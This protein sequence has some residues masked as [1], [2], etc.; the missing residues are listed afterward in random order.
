MTRLKRITNKI[1]GETASTVGTEEFGAEIGQFGSAKLGT[2]NATGDVATIQSLPAWDNG[3]IDAVIPNQQYPTLPEMTGVFKVITHQTG[4]LHQEG[5]S[6]WD[7]ATEYYKESYVKYIPETITYTA[8]ASIGTSTGITGASVDVD[9]FTSQITAQGNYTFT[10]DGSNWLYNEMTTNLTLYG[11]A[12]TGTPVEDDEIIISLVK[13]VT[14]NE[15]KIYISNTDNN[16]NNNPSTDAINWREFVT[17]GGGAGSIETFCITSGN[18]NSDGQ[19]DLLVVDSSVNLQFKVGN[20]FNALNGVYADG[21]RFVSESIDTVDCSTL[22][23]GDYNIFVDDTTTV[24]LFSNA[25]YRQVKEPTSPSANDVWLDTSVKPYVSKKYNG[26]TWDIY[27][28]IPLPQ[29]ITIAS[30]VIS[31]INKVGYY[32]DGMPWNNTGETTEALP[33]VIIKKWRSGQSEWRLYSDR[34]LEQQG[35]LQDFVS[36][37]AVMLFYSYIDNTYDIQVTEVSKNATD[38]IGYEQAYD[39]HTSYFRIGSAIQY[40]DF[41]WRTSGYVSEAVFKQILRS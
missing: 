1:F 32:N 10:F 39:V 3:W 2:Y 12:Y 15:S 40:M 19:A 36:S 18:I 25:I 34:R 13:T 27:N 37:S 31:S 23:D 17:G 22:A 8:S 30:G 26:L 5:L 4:Y 6:E 11:I 41:C 21:S 28:K 24:D 7:S 9:T 29:N 20:T 38:T 14:Q 35:Y 33:T 16:I